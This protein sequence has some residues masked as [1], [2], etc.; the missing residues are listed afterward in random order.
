MSQSV[1]QEA[2]T[3]LLM[4]K[5]IFPKGIVFKDGEGGG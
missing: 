5:G 1:Q 4:E 2:V 3:Q